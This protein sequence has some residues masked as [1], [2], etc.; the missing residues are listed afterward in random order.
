MEQILEEMSVFFNARADFYD[1]H[2]IDDLGL[3]VFYETI[4]DCFVAPISRLLDL[5]CG[6]GLEFERLF[7]KNPDMKVTGIDLSAEMLKKIKEKYPRKNFRLICGSYFDVDF[8]GL[9]DHVLSTY[10]LHHF[11]EEQKLELYRK[12]YAALEPGGLFV[13]GD[14]TVST[15]ERQHELLVA[16]DKK[17]KEQGIADGEFYHFDT[18]FTP[19]TE[20]RLMTT[21]GFAS[22]EIVRQWENTTII[23]AKK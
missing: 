5:G 1:S 16:N 18:P 10:S 9:Y 17:R 20:I 6:T 13:L 19:E 14:Y 23:I 2:M 4:A 22:A 7:E 11:S 3:D 12:I 8:D 21:A 15:I